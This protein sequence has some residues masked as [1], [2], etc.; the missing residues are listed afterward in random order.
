MVS[1]KKN[2]KLHIGENAPQKVVLWNW[3]TECVILSQF[4]TFLFCLHTQKRLCIFDKQNNMQNI[5]LNWCLKILQNMR[6]QIYK[7]IG[8][9][10][11]ISWIF[12]D[13]QHSIHHMC[14]DSLT[15]SF[16]LCWQTCVCIVYTSGLNM[17]IWATESHNYVSYWAISL[18]KEKHHCFH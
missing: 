12:V 13:I 6:T 3:A 10:F 18:L 4:N 14:V 15:Q 17:S 9:P 1:K 2:Y 7:L 8:F 5:S 11:T 16:S